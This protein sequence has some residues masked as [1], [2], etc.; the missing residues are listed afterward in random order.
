MFRRL[1]SLSPPPRGAGLFSEET[2]LERPPLLEGRD[3]ITGDAV[4]SL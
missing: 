1:P 2:E 3:S 4:R